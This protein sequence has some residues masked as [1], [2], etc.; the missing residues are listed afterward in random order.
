MNLHPLVNLRTLVA[1]S[2]A[3]LLA[4]AY[5][6]PV[7]YTGAG[8]NAVAI[9]AVRDLFRVDVGGGTVAGA[10]GSFGGV[11]REINWDGVPDSLAAPSNLPLN[12]FNVNSPRGAVF[13]TPGT[14]VAVSANAGVAPIEFDNIN[15]TYSQIFQTF[16]AQRLF[17]AIGSNVVDV[18]FFAA[19]TTNAGSTSAFASIFTD[20]DL[21]NT[22]AIEYFDGTISLGLFTVP[23][24]NNGLSFLGVRFDAGERITRVR[25]TSGNAALGP[26]D[27]GNTDVVAMDD[28]LY[29]EPQQFRAV[30]E[31]SSLALVALGLVGGLARYRQRRHG[32]G[33]KMQAT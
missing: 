10:N 19:G 3:L 27:G 33:S 24:F 15:P 5:S 4:P 2:A 9:T 22:T 8:A 17:A 32:A 13:S 11:R 14:G 1:A 6:A 26:N 25:I 18:N 16:S 23:V 30:P 12:F 31:P 29:A 7:V 28:F 20:V 21:P